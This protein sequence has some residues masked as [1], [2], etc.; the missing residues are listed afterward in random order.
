MPAEK[1]ERKKDYLEGFLAQKPEPVS[2]ADTRRRALRKRDRGAARTSTI[3][4][5]R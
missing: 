4:K 3:R 1:L 5:S 2:A